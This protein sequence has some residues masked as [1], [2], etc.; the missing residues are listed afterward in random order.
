MDN[1]DQLEAW[2][3][4]LSERQLSAALY[5]FRNRKFA[6]AVYDANSMNDLFDINDLAK[7]QAWFEDNFEVVEE[8]MCEAAREHMRR[9]LDAL[10]LLGTEG[11]DDEQP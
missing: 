8:V 4:S 9:E 11:D 3:A 1:P 7:A 2:A 6:A 10:D 5:E